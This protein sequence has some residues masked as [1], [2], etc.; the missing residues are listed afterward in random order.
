MGLK[1]NLAVSIALLALAVLTCCG[2]AFAYFSSSQSGGDNTVNVGE[3][4][5]TVDD[6]GI[7]SS[8]SNIYFKAP[9]IINVPE[10]VDGI[11][12]VDGMPGEADYDAKHAKYLVDHAKYLVDHARFLTDGDDK[13]FNE[14]AVPITIKITNNSRVKMRI[15]N[16]SVEATTFVSTAQKTDYSKSMLSFVFDSNLGESADYASQIR[17]DCDFP[18]ID[19]VNDLEKTK[20]R[21]LEGQK[22]KLASVSK[23]ELNAKVGETESFLEFSSVAWLDYREYKKILD[24][25]LARPNGAINLRV[26]VEVEQFDEQLD[27]TVVV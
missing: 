11:D 12:G 14:Y 15:V 6:G 21:I 1:K 9:T 17:E 18:L 23:Q 4:V 5:F 8:E 3:F 7:T 10:I 24:A 25:S 2:V 13:Y 27:R 16:I 19:G 20:A 26:S 22:V